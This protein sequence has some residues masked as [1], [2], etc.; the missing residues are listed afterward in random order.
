MAET[1]RDYINTKEEL[2]FAVFCVE[3][4]AEKTG[5]DPADIYDLLT[6]E[7]DLLKTYIVPC[8]DIL[9][10]QSKEYIVNDLMALMKERGILR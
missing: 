2:N 5:R 9:H 6:K 8:F 1:T 10:T 4:L 7:S 3:S